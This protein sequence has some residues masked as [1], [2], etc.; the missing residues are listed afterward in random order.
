MSYDELAQWPHVHQYSGPS[1]RAGGEGCQ[2]RSDSR[3]TCGTWR[4]GMRASF[5]RITYLAFLSLALCTTIP[6]RLAGQESDPHRLALAGRN[7]SAEAARALELQVQSS[8]DDVD[9]RSK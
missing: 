1:L 5:L 4:S 6:S 7:L 9:A 8:P 2:T 3:S